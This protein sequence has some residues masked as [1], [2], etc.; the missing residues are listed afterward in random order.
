MKKVILS[1]STFV[2][3]IIIVCMTISAHSKVFTPERWT[4]NVNTRYKM[5]DSLKEK[6]NLYNMTRED[7]VGLLG[8]PRQPYALEPPAH[9]DFLEYKVGNFTIDPT[10]L[11]IEFE[12]EKV[13][14][15]YL[16][17]EFRSSKQPL[18]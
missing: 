11:T 4:K 16:Y 12:N 17:T 6:Y 7:I 3:I 2:V 14:D 10:M 8:E 5:L 13:V 15:I 18:Y 9:E 1:I